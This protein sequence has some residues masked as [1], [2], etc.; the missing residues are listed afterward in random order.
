MNP[1]VG[2]A[3]IEPAVTPAAQPPD[4]YGTVVRARATDRWPMAHVSV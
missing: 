1:P 2:A 3:A 4:G